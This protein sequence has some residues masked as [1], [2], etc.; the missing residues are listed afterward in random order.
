M[1]PSTGW[2]DAG[3]NTNGIPVEGI[4]PIPMT[5]TYSEGGVFFG[6]T[7]EVDFL[8]IAALITLSSVAGKFGYTIGAKDVPPARMFQAI[9]TQ[10]KVFGMCILDSFTPPEVSQEFFEFNAY[11]QLACM[12]DPLVGVSVGFSDSPPATD[13]AFSEGSPTVPTYGD[14]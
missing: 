1:I 8:Q 2:L 5:G 3:L 14:A 12:V 13:A 7:T 10:P 9:L 11:T 4:L 6:G